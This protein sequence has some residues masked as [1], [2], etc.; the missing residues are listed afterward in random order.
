MNDAA[1]KVV[2]S[3]MSAALAR[4]MVLFGVPCILAGSFWLTGNFIAL[5]EMAAVQAAEQARIVSQVREL[6]EY[7]RDAFGRGQRMQS[8]LAAI[9]D[10][11]ADQK[12]T[13]ERLAERQPPR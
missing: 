5:R 8:D 1:K 3:V 2:D 9:R 13:L 4:L 10:M 12:R 7:R 6:E 11:L